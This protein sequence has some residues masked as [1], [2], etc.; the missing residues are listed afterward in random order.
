MSIS[1][2]NF[3]RSRAGHSSTA[4]GHQGPREGDGCCH[5]EP[6]LPPGIGLQPRR[7]FLSPSISASIPNGPGPPEAPGTITCHGPVTGQVRLMSPRPGSA[8][9]PSLDGNLQ[10]PREKEASGDETPDRRTDG[11]EETGSY[12]HDPRQVGR[13]SA[14]RRPGL[15]SP[16][17]G[18][19]SASRLPRHAALT[20]LGSQLLRSL[21]IRPH[22]TAQTVPTLLPRSP[23]RTNRT[24]T[25][26][27][28]GTHKT[29]E[30]NNKKKWS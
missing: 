12:A 23:P 28:D 4:L 17:E 15:A 13:V 8:P 1:L 20:S 29:K 25:L 30:T 14:R 7:S 19:L 26:K 21:P 10:Q 9:A 18:I 11:L 2:P 27:T 22:H 16:S 24:P 3:M 5:S 6:A